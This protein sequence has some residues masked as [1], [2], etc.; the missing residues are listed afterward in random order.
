MKYLI[1]L[2]TLALPAYL[3]RFSV[4]GIPT[5]LL[6]VLI[7]LVFIIGLVIAIKEHR[8][9]P[10]HAV[11]L[12]ILLLL[13][14][15]VISVVISPVKLVALGE[16]KAF[17]IDPIMVF[18]LILTFLKKEDF[19]WIFNGLVIGSIFVSGHAIF[20]KTIGN[21]TPDARVVG[22]FGYS[23]NYLALFLTPLTALVL[24]YNFRL[25]A[26]RKVENRTSK[27][28][29]TWGTI[30]LALIA[31]DLSGSRAAF[32]ALGGGIIFYLIVYFRAQTQG[33]LWLKIIIGAIL[34]LLVG[35]AWWLNRPNFTL[36]PAV[37]GRVTSSN[38]IRA[39]I[40]QTSLELGS[41]HP[42]LGVGLGNFQN[43]FRQLTYN[44]VN[45]SAYITPL[46]LTPHNLF[47]MFWLSTG[48]LGLVAL[49]WL[50][51]IF[52]RTGF[53]K[54]ATKPAV[55]ILLCAMTALIL[56][57]FVDTPYF[58]NDLSLIFWL[59]FASM[60]IY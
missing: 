11:W 35:V 27:I 50:L 18:W 33:K 49:V 37:G 8:E 55:I 45:F 12:P 36:D 13:V 32:L 47:L 19:A 15:A 54:L 9:F 34:V 39:Q 31:L 1:F 21:L 28:I 4:L 53:A 20:E 42:F 23:P 52:Y 48:L 59:I 24:A 2:I 6:E 30:I 17:F 7:Y 38:N 26:D 29:A 3:I 60:L 58:K 5:T 40:W 25:A 56:Q 22:I 14:A 10:K 51:A 43:S 57:G 44:R 46:A 41:K 16:F